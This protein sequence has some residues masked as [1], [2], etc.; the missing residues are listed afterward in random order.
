MNMKVLAQ[1]L[2]IACLC[3]LAVAAQ[4]QGDAYPSKP[5]K[6]ISDASPGATPDVVMRLV[7]D[8]LGQLWG[9]QVIG[10]NHPGAGGS[11][12]TRVASESAPDGYTLFMPA[13]STF[14]SL[15]GAAPNLPVQVPR[16]FIPIGFVAENPM[17]ISRSEEHTSELQSLRHL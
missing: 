17:F 5:V 3:L 16:D 10:V 14:A 9:Q 11:I 12:A 4:A 1:L 2:K 13:L 8:R 6:I 7:A 15:P